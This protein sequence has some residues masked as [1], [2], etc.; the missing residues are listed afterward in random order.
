MTAAQTNIKIRLRVSTDD[1]AIAAVVTAAFG[2]PD[3]A[4]L[5]AQLRTDGDMVAEF[6]ALDAAAVV[7]HIAFSRLDVRAG[8]EALRTVALAPVAVAPGHQQ[9]GIG[10]A[11]IRHAH[12]CLRDEG[13]DLVVVLGHPAY[14]PQF[15]FSSLLAKLLDAPYAGEA[16]MALELKP[17]VLGALKWR[18]TY[19]RA[20]DPA[21]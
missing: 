15:G 4:T 11:L 5:I 21:H 3:E 14:Y 10:G 9:Q 1:A 16:F 6:V 7:G 18:V 8:S 17:G 12:T 20:F 19:P 2:G 13:E